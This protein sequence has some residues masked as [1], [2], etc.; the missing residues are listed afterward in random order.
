MLH[1]A[2]PTSAEWIAQAQNEL[3]T[4]LLDHTHCEKKA[5][6]TA[7]NLIFRYADKLELMRPLSE[8]AREELTHFELMLGVLEKRGVAFRRLEPSRYAARLV[9]VCRKA[10]PFRLMDTL[11][12]C[13]MIEARSCERIGILG[14]VL[15]EQE[16]E[17]AEIYR[18]LFESEARHYST[19]LDI[20]IRIF[21]KEEVMPRLIEVA[22]HESKVLGDSEPALRFHS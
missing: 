20:A 18:S 6:S 11:L 3:D 9:G 19:Y 7:I 1:L 5:A 15:Q 8:L 2:E 13:A 21:S 16:P 10:E 12:C 22:A 14:R 4:L 17:L